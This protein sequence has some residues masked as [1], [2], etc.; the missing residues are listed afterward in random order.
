MRILFIFDRVAHYHISLFQTLEKELENIGHTLFLMSGEVQNN[1]VVGRV[2]SSEKVI[3]N[4]LKYQ[5][6][7]IQ[8]FSYT[9]RLQ[10]H[11]IATL[12]QIQPDVI[13]IPGHVGNLSF[14]RLMLLK[15][16]F[17]FKLFS[18]Q[19]G[20]EYN[21]NLFKK[22]MTQ[23]F[24]NFFDFHLAYHSNAEKYLLKHNVKKSKIQV[25][26]NTIDESLI[27]VVCKREAKTILEDKYPIL[28]NK[29]ILLFVGAI[30]VEKKLDL[31]IEAFLKLG[32]PEKFLII[33]G[34]G[35]YLKELRE[36]YGQMESLLFTGRLI[37]N[38]G[39]F[40]DASDLFILPGTG[41]LAINEAMI[42]G[43]PVISSYADGSADDLVIDNFNGFRLRENSVEELSRY[44]ELLVN[45]R[46]LLKKM[47]INS[48]KHITDQYNFAGFLQKIVDC[49]TK[50][51]N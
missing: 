29:I 26:G 14:W 49:L 23:L 33:V 11:T 4:E 22:M 30:L 27:P 31:L 17:K 38:V 10:K 12:R 40:F 16:I 35:P 34:D 7:E 2:G 39:I 47:G 48:K 18:W 3:K 42:H 50:I 45:D 24:L 5:Y 19:C 21:P 25:I 36:K 8:I 51:S 43:L 32:K 6:S 15:K 20:Y 41:G 28:K 13:V 37:E 46:I 1:K 9:I 44:L